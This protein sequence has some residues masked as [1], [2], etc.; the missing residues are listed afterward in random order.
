MKKFYRSLIRSATVLLFLITALTA[1]AQKRIVTGTITDGGGGPMPGVNVIL[2]GTTNGTATAGDGSYSIEAADG[3]ILQISFIGFAPQEIN[4]GSQTRI[5]VKMTEDVATLQEVVIVGYGE[6]RR[7]DLSTAQTSISSDQI[8]KTVNTTIEQAIQ[9]RAAGVYITQN[10]GQ[11]GGGV[12][13]NI[14]GVNSISGSNEPLYVVDGVQIQQSSNVSYGSTS[15][16]NPLAGLNPSDIQNMEILQGP[17]ATAIYGSRGTNGVV[18]I[19]TK[20]GK[21]GETKVSYGYLY[22]LQDKPEILPVMNLPQYAE[23][24][25][26]IRT[27]TGGT[28]PVEFTNP[29]LLGPGTNWQDAL[30]KTAPLHKHQLSLSGGTEKTTFYLS[31]EYFDQEGIALGSEFKRYSVRLNIDNQVRKWLKIGANLNF[32]QTNEALASTQENVINNALSLAPNIPVKNPNGT[33]GGAD[34][35]NGS[36]VQFTPL[37]PVAIANLVQN[38]LQRRGFIGGIYTDVNIL[39]GLVFKTSLNTNIGLSRQDYFIPTYRLGNKTNDVASLTVSTGNNTYW[40]WNQLLQYNTKFG[41]HDLGLMASH[42]AQESSY[43]NLSGARTNFVS[44]EIPDLNIGDSQT[45]T[46]GG[47]QGEWAMESYFGRVNYSFSDKYMLQAAVR[48]DGSVNFGPDNKWGVFP[49]ASAAWRISQEA[50]FSDITFI[51]ELKLRI[52][53]GLTGSQGN[54]SF[55]GPL[56]STSTPWG[57]GFILGR[58]GNDLLQWEETNTNNI[59]FNVAF[60]ENRIQLEGDFYVKKTDNLIMTAPLPEYMGT[61]GEGAI[62]P[63]PINIGAMENRGWSFS[64]NTV[65]VDK[66]GFSWTSNFNISGF[67]TK[68]T[69][70]YSES[71][72]VD[73]RPWFVGDTGSGNNWAQR[74]AVGFAPWLF[75]GY[76]YDGIFQSVEEINSSPIPADNAGARRAVSEASIWVG[77]IKFKDLNGDNIIDDRDRTNI[78]NPW[79]KFTFG[80]TNT[81]TYKGFDLNILLTAVYG[82]DVFNLL[83]F[84]NTNPNNINLGRNLLSEAFDYAKVEGEAEEAHLANPGTHIPRITSSDVNGNR[85]RFTDQFVEDGSYLRVKNIQLTYNLPGA[86]LSNQN[87]VKGARFS[88]GAQ[89]LAT[90]T[91]FKG[92]DPEVGAYVGRDVAGDNQSIGL[93]YGRYPLTP[94]YTFSVGIDF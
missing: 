44:N 90:F 32:S 69:K 24:Y 89:N 34:E 64:V 93:D 55:Y 74:A 63:P 21:A 5:D 79:P 11:P 2:K 60:Q 4:V 65:N 40:N 35:A 47:G 87:V 80:F 73:R 76:L 20:R 92:Y 30:F 66:G 82:N 16:T 58:Y 91:K 57:S 67:K 14:R 28:V 23:M 48:A 49:S 53:T 18:L 62:S 15:S 41:K 25:A 22:S 77:D 51:N 38:D 52:E 31:G 61:A 72:F 12:S 19:T 17:S 33:W 26:A 39:K 86:L 70:F 10:T 78:G 9:G 45:A 42:E 43:E 13:V 3:D 81:F 71:A 75:Q 56:N 68:V 59:G 27:L 7:S 83:R 84:N 29:S 94:V 6:M 8:E 85:L 1:T 50:F 36:S 54:T 46:N 37:N 88:V